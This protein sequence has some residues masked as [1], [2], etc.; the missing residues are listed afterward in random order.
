[1]E[2]RTLKHPK[3]ITKNKDA[4]PNGWLVPLYNV[5]DGFFSSGKE[6]KQVYMTVISPQSSKGPHLHYIR[7]GFF[8][9]IKGNV[10]IVLKTTEGYKEFRSGEAHEYLSVEVPTGV[11]ALVINDGDSE[12]FVLNM[13]NPAWTPTMNDEHDADFSDYKSVLNG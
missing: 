7:T 13:P 9:C 12:A 11:P 5:N 3:F 4:S 8:T 2:I 1:M 6:P 10:R